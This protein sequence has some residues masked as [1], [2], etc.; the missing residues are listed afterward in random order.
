VSRRVLQ[1]RTGVGTSYTSAFSRAKIQGRRRAV[2]LSHLSSAKSRVGL[3]FNCKN[4]PSKC[5]S[6]RFNCNRH[7]V[8][9]MHSKPRHNRLLSHSSRSNSEDRRSAG[10][11][12]SAEAGNLYLLRR[13]DL[14]ILFLFLRHGVDK[15]YARTAKSPPTTGPESS[16]LRK[17]TVRTP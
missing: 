2:R 10:S 3:R 8:S 17:H 9:G 6:L 13:G 11:I 5:A 12:S 15:H 7:L 1:S 14:D 4:L 16:W